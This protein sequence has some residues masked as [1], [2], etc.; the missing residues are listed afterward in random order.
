MP[1]TGAF[2]L[3]VLEAV[4]T[5]DVEDVVVDEVEGPP[6]AVVLVIVGGTTTGSTRSSGARSGNCDQFCLLRAL[7]DDCNSDTSIACTQVR[8]SDTD[9]RFSQTRTHT[10]LLLTLTLALTFDLSTQNHV[11]CSIS[12]GALYQV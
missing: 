6:A 2:L 8:G 3:E 11:T 12:Q 10:V 5:A 4:G 7:M 1:P 9:K